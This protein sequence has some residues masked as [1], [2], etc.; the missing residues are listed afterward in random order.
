MIDID[1]YNRAIGWL[2]RCLAEFRNNPTNRFMK[3]GLLHSV[4]V[5]YNISEA[6]LREVYT[7]IDDERGAILI[8]TRELI[9]CAADYGLALSTPL[10]WMRYGVVIEEAREKCLAST[11]ET[12]DLPIELLSI[13]A[14]EL[15]SFAH[16]LE[17]RGA[18]RA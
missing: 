9:R 1:N 2:R 4:E 12:F 7:S 13:F 11:D 8:S 10:Q 3:L 18:A 5:T 17:H 15:D 16:T 14:D 6:L